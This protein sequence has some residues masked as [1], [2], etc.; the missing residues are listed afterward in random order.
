[1][2]GWL[3][4]LGG[5]PLTL[6]LSSLAAPVPGAELEDF[7]GTY[8]GV[9]SVDNLRA[10]TRAQRD[11][12]IVIERY[13]DDGFRI[14]W[15]NVSL[16]DGRR[17]LPGVERRVQTVLFAPAEDSEF[18]VEVRPSSLFH[19]QGE[20]QP[21]MGDAVRWAALL[22]DTLRVT[23]FQVLDDGRYEMQI[24]DRTLTEQGLDVDFDRILDDQVVRT[25]RGH[26]VRAE[27][28]EDE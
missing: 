16:V 6:V 27:T 20:M 26:T 9:A 13:K 24:Y 3:R 1:M 4:G 28:S 5:V 11:M 21:V 18:Y 23:T 7:F 19:E 12:D 2:K 8:V 10:G 15:I 25:I 22:D 14:R 17:D